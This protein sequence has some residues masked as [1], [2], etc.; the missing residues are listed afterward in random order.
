M[1]NKNI[2]RS[3]GYTEEMID[4]ASHL[5]D[6]KVAQTATQVARMVCKEYDVEY[7]ESI[8]RYYRKLFN[9]NSLL[10]NS[11]SYQEAVKRELPVKRVYFL[12]SAQNSTPVNSNLLKNMEVYADKLDA[13]IGVIAMRYRNPNLYDEGLKENYWDKKIENYLIASRYSL[14]KNMVIG[15]DVFIPYTTKYPLRVA[16][17]LSRDFSFIVGHPKQDMMS[18]PVLDGS[19]EKKLYSTGSITIPENYSQTMSGSEAQK[20]HKMGF[21]I[22]I[23][24][25]NN[26]V[27]R[28][29]EA[30][31]KGNFQDILI[32]V[33]NGKIL[34][35]LGKVKA[36]VAGDLH[37]TL[38]DERVLAKTREIIKMTKPDN[39]VLHDV[40][41]AESISFF[42]RIDI[43][44]QL[45]LQ[46]KGML[47]LEREIDLSLKMIESFS[48]DV[49]RVIIPRANHHNF[50]DIWLT[51]EDWKKD[52]NNARIYLRLAAIKATAHADLKK[53]IY[54]ALVDSAFD[55]DKVVTLGYDDSFRVGGIELSQHGDKGSD[56]RRGSVVQYRKTGIPHIVGHGHSA[57]KEGDIVMVGVTTEKRLG[58]NQ[59]YSGWSHLHA[60]ITENNKVQYIQIPPE[61]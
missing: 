13:A 40:L 14:H 12:T 2:D 43:F 50:I 33:E 38:E 26:V 4:R 51:R 41:S 47:S 24:D 11:A 19:P 57:R 37:S 10:I 15:A 44:R 61:Q 3:Y 34:E 55:S 53:G 21:L 48:E 59:G 49:G 1:D 23:I 35:E 60:I 46:D 18:V 36:F 20:E 56:G 22:V 9:G 6:T 52:I 17:N 27:V 5:L 8:G 30:D 16:E 39:L 58:Y 25:G 31:R 45:E 54:A 7:D 28:N 29:V 32:K 42:T